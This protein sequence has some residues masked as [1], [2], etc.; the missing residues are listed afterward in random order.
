MRRATFYPLWPRET[1]VKTILYETRRTIFRTARVVGSLEPRVYG[2]VRTRVPRGLGPGDATRVAP[3]CLCAERT[4][5][6]GFGSPFNRAVVLR[7]GRLI[8]ARLTPRA[9]APLATY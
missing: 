4:T 7:H 8:V 6:E 5:I 2:E 3:R 9:R 1:R